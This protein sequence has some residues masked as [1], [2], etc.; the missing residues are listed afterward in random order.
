MNFMGLHFSGYQTSH[1]FSCS[2][3]CHT[4][5]FTVCYFFFKNK[6]SHAASLDMSLL[7]EISMIKGVAGHQDS[8]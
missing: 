4:R 1:Q 6:H 5:E 7:H 8:T 3:S 2:Y